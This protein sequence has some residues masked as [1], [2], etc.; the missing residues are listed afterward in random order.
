[1][2]STDQ[3]IESFL[4]EEL[5]KFVDIPLGYNEELVRLN[6][7]FLFCQNDTA[8][9]RFIAFIEEYFQIQIP[10]GEIDYYFLSDLTI[11]SKTISSYLHKK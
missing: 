10:D 6:L 8:A 7:F 9:L 11:M 4:L 1:M 3:D 5:K 2:L